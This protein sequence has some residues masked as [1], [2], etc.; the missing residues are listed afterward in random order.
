M[1][2]LLLNNPLHANNFSQLVHH[3]RLADERDL[4]V[5]FA[6]IAAREAAAVGAHNE[7]SKLYQMAIEF[8]D[9]K[10]PHKVELYERHAYECYLT[11]QLA[12]AISSQE[13]ALSIWKERKVSLKI[14]DTLRFLSRILWFE[15]KTLDVEKLA[16]QAVEVLENGFP[17]RERALAYGNLSQLG[18]LADD[19]DKTFFWGNKAINLAMRME[20]DEV[21]SH[22]LNNV[23]AI[24]MKSTLTQKEGEDKLNQSLSI[25]LA[26]GFHEHAARAYTN[27]SYGLLR[28][29]QYQKAADAFDSGL[30]YCDEHDVQS[31]TYYMLSEK[32][33]LLFE[34][35][36]QQEAES[37]AVSLYANTF[38]PS[39]VRI[40]VITVLAVMK[41]R[42]GE[43]AEAKAL[44][45]EGLPLA[46]VT[47]EAQ[48]IAPLLNAELEFCWITGDVL[49]KEDIIAA[50]ENLFPQKHH[51]W[52]YT[53][54]SRWRL[55]CG[56]PVSATIQYNGP[57]RFESEGNWI[58]AAEEWGK[59]GC[60]YEQALALLQGDEDNQRSGL[61]ILDKLDASAVSEMIRAKLKVKGVRNIPRGPRES[62]LNN[63][64]QLTERQIDVLRLLQQGLQNTEIADKLFISP[65]TVDHHISAI[66][67]KLEVNTRAKAV[68]E[69][70]KLGILI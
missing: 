46:R 4:I 2:K 15:G 8:T 57:F 7:A 69:A 1:L 38:H 25:A 43:L 58:M 21:L 19:L 13:H 26:N 32:V 3:A 55:K 12:A 31:W 9:D 10:A 51:S 67:S 28:S 11:N 56:L 33:R 39:I 36:F 35:G 20:D 63:P 70:R 66:L 42:R 6:P 49:P 30:K 29:K 68:L 62:T 34:T 64:A 17:T 60:R 14:G 41:M 18:M 48:R 40:G 23:G 53:E 27:L 24:L 37:I 54:F 47:K 45:H 52:Q 59:L 44:I 50:E 65:K 16:L 22:A 61:L 5:N